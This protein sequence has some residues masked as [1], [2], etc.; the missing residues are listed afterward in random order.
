[1]RTFSSKTPLTHGDFILTVKG[2]FLQR[3]MHFDVTVCAEN[4]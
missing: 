3:D 1:M 4:E 2:S